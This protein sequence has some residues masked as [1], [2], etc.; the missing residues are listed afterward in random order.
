MSL[1]RCVECGKEFSDKAP[2]CPNC[3]CP[4]SAILDELNENDTNN[5]EIASLDMDFRFQ[6]KK[7]EFHANGNNLQI[8]KNSV[9]VVDDDIRNFMLLWSQTKKSLGTNQTEIVFTHKTFNKPL[10]IVL[11]KENF[12]TKEAD[13][14]KL[15]SF[16]ELCES[17]MEMNIQKSASESY[18]YTMPKSLDEIQES[19]KRKCPKCGSENITYQV[20]ELGRTV[21]R[22]DNTS[23]RKAGRKALTIATMGVWGLTAKPQGKEH[24]YVRNGT[25]AICQNCGHAWRI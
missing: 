24:S 3:G 19:A 22:T 23:A 8:A 18:V 1:I 12:L 13:Y 7:Y 10:Q 9:I 5:E 21:S 14:L 11:V 15:L 4:T 2:A 17:Y 25:F 16:K 6:Y 20:Q